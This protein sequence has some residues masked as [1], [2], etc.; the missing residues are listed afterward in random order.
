[1]LK[2]PRQHVVIAFGRKF[3]WECLF[4]VLQYFSGGGGITYFIINE[5]RR[6]GINVLFASLT[7]TCL[8]S[9]GLNLIIYGSKVVTVNTFLTIVFCFNTVDNKLIT[10]IFHIC[11]PFYILLLLLKDNLFGKVWNILF[12]IWQNFQHFTWIIPDSSAIL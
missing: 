4:I 6:N 2:T 12:S 9:F 3:T 8:K 11:L 5:E 7:F 1:M 10:E